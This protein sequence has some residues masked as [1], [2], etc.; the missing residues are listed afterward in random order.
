MKYGLYIS[1]NAEE[2]INDIE[3][4]IKIDMNEVDKYFAQFDV[5]LEKLS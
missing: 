5:Y 3:N 1:R 4:N 2:L